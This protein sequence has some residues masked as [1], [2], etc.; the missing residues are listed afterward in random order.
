MASL[1]LRSQANHLRVDRLLRA[2]GG[3]AKELG[4]ASFAAVATAKDGR[5]AQTV[6][7]GADAR[8]RP[9]TLGALTAIV[10]AVFI[11]PGLLRRKLAEREDALKAK[12]AVEGGAAEI[13][14]DMPAAA[15]PAFAVRVSAFLYFARLT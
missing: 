4:C 2:T 1:P 3:R 14:R 8:G 7:V 13:V 5:T 6:M 9:H 11:N 12:A 10:S 15:L